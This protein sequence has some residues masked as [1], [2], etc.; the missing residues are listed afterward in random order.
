MTM[1]R[2]K[3]IA[4]LIKK[5]KL[6][7]LEDDIYSFLGPKEY[8]PISHFVPEQFVYMHSISKSLCSGMRVGYIAYS[9]IFAEKLTRGIYNINVKNPGVKC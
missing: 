8:L 5:Y 3:D 2:R 9:N 7:L 1:E 4:K 6:I